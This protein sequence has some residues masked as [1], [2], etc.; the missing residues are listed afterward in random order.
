MGI[1]LY[2]LL[3]LPKVEIKIGLPVKCRKCIMYHV[4]VGFKMFLLVCHQ[5]FCS[6]CWIVILVFSPESTVIFWMFFLLSC[7]TT[8]KVYLPPTS[9][10]FIDMFYYFS[11]RS[12]YVLFLQ[13]PFL[14]N[15]S[16]IQSLGPSTF[17]PAQHLSH[18]EECRTQPV[19]RAVPAACRRVLGPQNKM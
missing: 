14:Q 9:Y 6:W 12:L 18:A 1:T 10:S 15:E 16:S 4:N 17:F 5:A 19:I 3:W 11:K 13:A 2:E 8:L 7:N